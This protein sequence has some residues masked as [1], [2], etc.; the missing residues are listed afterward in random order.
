MECPLMRRNRHLVSNASR[1]ALAL[2]LVAQPLT[3]A[4]VLA[5]AFQGTAVFDANKIAISNGSGTA[6][7]AA[8]AHQS[9]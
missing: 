8:L 4:P 6:S 9:T 1:S 5:Q 2:L 7:I 3:T